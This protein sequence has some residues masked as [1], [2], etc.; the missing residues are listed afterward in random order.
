MSCPLVIGYGNSLR[1]D[2]GVGWRAADLLEE[3]L[4]GHD[5]EI[6]RCHQLTP[7]LARKLAGACMVIFLDA[8]V[9][10]PFQSVTLTRIRPKPGSVGFSHHLTPAHLLRLSQALYGNVA[11]AH[12][13]TAGVK[14]FAFTEHLTA[15]GEA[16]AA[17]MA[18]IACEMITNRPA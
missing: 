7:E 4:T 2:D 6:V 17:R 18:D 3:R 13:V 14:D 15:E 12:V 11:P 5:T 8:S 10:R 16:C 9:D 1:Q